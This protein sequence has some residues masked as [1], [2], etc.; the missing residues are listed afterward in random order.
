MAVIDRLLLT[1]AAGRVATL[2]RPGLAAIAREVRLLDLRP[3]EA[4]LPHETQ[5][6]GD[7]RDVAPRAVAGCGGVVHLA[8]VSSEA[9]AASIVAAN[10]IATGALYRA[11]CD[12]GIRRILFASTNHV[13]GFYPV[14]DMIGPTDPVRPDSLYAA[15]KVW[16]EAL[17]R[18]YFDSAGIEGVAVRLGSVF[19]RPETFRHLATWMS[20]RDL[21]S[22]IRHIFAV[23]R[24]GF[25]VMYGV[26]DNQRTWW[27]AEGYPPGWRPEDRA[28]DME[29]PKGGAERQWQGGDLPDRALDANR[30]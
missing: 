28:E 15:S 16:G 11:A 10:I 21:L 30:R 29:S 12:A 24:L 4:L 13:T 7:L 25:T 19:A 20:P 18:Y 27:R 14:T 9:D 6:T 17:A 22:L 8:A 26:S 3:V 2:I 23:E 5:M 1:G